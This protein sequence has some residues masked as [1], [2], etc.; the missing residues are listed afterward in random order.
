MCCEILLLNITLTPV[1]RQV[2]LPSHHTLTYPSSPFSLSRSYNTS[3]LIQHHFKMRFSVGVA[4]ACA[5]STI[6]QPIQP[7]AK[8][9]STVKTIDTLEMESAVE[10]EAAAMNRGKKLHWIGDHG[11]ECS[12]RVR[13]GLVHIKRKHG[14]GH[15]NEKDKRHVL[16]CL[17]GF[18]ASE[19]FW[20]W[21]DKTN[22]Y[23][24]QWQERNDKR[25]VE[26]AEI[27]GA[28]EIADASEADDA[29]DI[30]DAV[31]AEH[32]VEAAEKKPKVQKVPH[33]SGEK[34]RWTSP[35]GRSCSGRP[36]QGIVHIKR[37]HGA[38]HPTKKEKAR[39][40]DCLDGYIE[41]A[42]EDGTFSLYLGNTV[43]Y[44]K[45]WPHGMKKRSD[46][47]VE[48]DDAVEIDEAI[49]SDEAIEAKSHADATESQDAIEADSH[50][51]A[52]EHHGQKF[53]W[54]GKD[55]KKCIGRLHKGILHVGRIHGV[56]HP[57]ILDYA[58][59]HNCLNGME[60]MAQKEMR[61]ANLWPA[62]KEYYKTW[63]GKGHKRSVEAFESDEAVE[64]QEAVDAELDA[65]KKYHQRFTW[66]ARDGSGCKGHRKDGVV[67]INRKHGVGHPD[68]HD[69]SHV[70]RCFQGF[71]DASKEGP[72]EGQKYAKDTEVYYKA[73]FKKHY[74][75]FA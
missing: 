67:H 41:M 50:T 22:W 34:M 58:H 42:K 73:W 55:G 66:L 11:E 1:S 51:D 69:A 20:P 44:Y 9:V 54:K 71:M 57:D 26:G 46:E 47:A 64:S 16:S 15:P 18:L 2:L 43:L 7:V 17:Q 37:K 52:A 75:G 8:D 70:M 31:E 4:L 38:F 23:Y 6:A 48:S 61:Y 13:K 68:K 25:D 19:D 63:P 60:A 27:E 24:V 28:I 65:Q 32:G 14:A 35:K 59:V 62:T 12:G 39:V 33:H 30:E 53:I 49:E 72:W 21:H 45:S 40:M 29:V 56:F 10:A 5:I 74:H 3:N 36:K